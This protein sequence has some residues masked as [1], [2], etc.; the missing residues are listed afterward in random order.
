ML[1]KSFYIF[2]IIQ[3]LITNF[4]TC[5]FFATPVKATKSV[6]AVRIIP[7]LTIK[8]SQGQTALGTALCTRHYD[9]AE[10]LIGSGANVNDIDRDGH[11]LLHQAILRHDVEGALFLLQHRSDFAA[12]CVAFECLVF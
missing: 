9:I 3:A 6:D 2:I 8:D 10:L 5:N 7:N 11:T 12:R 1:S 4:Y